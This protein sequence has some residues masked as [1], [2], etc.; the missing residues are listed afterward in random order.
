MNVSSKNHTRFIKSITIL[1]FATYGPQVRSIR[2]LKYFIIPLK[3]ISSIY[4]TDF[5]SFLLL[6]PSVFAISKFS[7]ST[8]DQLIKDFLSDQD[9]PSKLD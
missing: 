2:L 8:S 3:K 9:I 1:N 6:Y 4:D 7:S 5:L